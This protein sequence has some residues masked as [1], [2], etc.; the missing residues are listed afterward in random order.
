MR[1]RATSARASV[2]TE[3][4][5]LPS[6]AA[7]SLGAYRHP[8]EIDGRTTGLPRRI[9]DQQGSWPR[10]GSDPAGH[11]HWAAEPVP[12][13]IDRQS[14]GDPRSAARQAVGPC[15]IDEVKNHLEE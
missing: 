3:K 11:V 7:Q 10:K 14:G 8:D 13:S 12:G 4:L 15:A 6:H 5:L 9:G 2:P 1:N